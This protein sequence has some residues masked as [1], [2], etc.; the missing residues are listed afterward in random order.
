MSRLRRQLIVRR[1]MNLMCAWCLVFG[2]SEL[3]ANQQNIYKEP[4]CTRTV[5][6]GLGGRATSRRVYST[7]LGRARMDER[8]RHMCGGARDARV[9]MQHITPDYSAGSRVGSE[10]R[11]LEARTARSPIYDFS[12][13]SGTGISSRPA[14]AAPSSIVIE[15]TGFPSISRAAF[16]PSAAHCTPSPTGAF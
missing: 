14:I 6:W 13:C 3:F 9:G 12:Q 15:A 8:P 5:A 16:D 4:H 1:L 10:R 7:D 2:V 11:R